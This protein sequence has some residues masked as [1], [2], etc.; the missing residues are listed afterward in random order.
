[1]CGAPWQFNTKHREKFG[2]HFAAQMGITLPLA[3][4]L[5]LYL[6]LYLHLHLHFVAQMGLAP[7]LAC[8]QICICANIFR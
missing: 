7:P 4:L 6:Y 5:Y 8:L 1:M 2:L 3:L